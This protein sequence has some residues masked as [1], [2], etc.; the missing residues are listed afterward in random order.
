MSKIPKTHLRAF[1]HWYEDETEER[2]AIHKVKAP[3]VTLDPLEGVT[4]DTVI[5]LVKVCESGTFTADR[6]TAIFLGL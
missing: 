4:L 1:L 3:R 2:T 5:A 6:D